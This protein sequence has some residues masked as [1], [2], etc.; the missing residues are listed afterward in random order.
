MG[1]GNA[2]PRGTLSTL[3]DILAGG[4]ALVDQAQNLGADVQR[5]LVEV[6]RGVEGQLLGLVGA[7]EER[8][9]ERL[10]ALVSGLAVTLRGEVDRVRDR[11]RSIEGRLA[12]VPKEGVRELIAPLQAVLGGASERAAAALARVEELGLRLQ[13][14]ERR[15]AEISR[16]TTRDT[17]DADDIKQRLDRDGQ[18]LTDL[19]R[20]VGTKLGELGALRERLTRIEARVLEYSKD[21]IARTGEQAGQRDRL[22]RLETRLSDLSKEQLARSV[23]TAGLRERLFRLEQRNGPAATRAPFTEPEPST[24]SAED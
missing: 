1:R 23:E 17:L 24:A 7:V 22:A 13:H 15:I 19:G 4:M 14:V 3:G 20:E 6:G 2:E 12:D 5:R 10:D 8:L 11:L 18:R 21:Q 9:G 16:E